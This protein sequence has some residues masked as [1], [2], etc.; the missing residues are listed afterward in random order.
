M[1][2]TLLLSCGVLSSQWHTEP[3]ALSV[4]VYHGQRAGITAEK[5]AEFDVVL[6]TYPVVEAEWR[7][8]INRYIQGIGIGLMERGRHRPQRKTMDFLSRLE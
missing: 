6:T 8:I 5:L 1:F 7:A 2:Y 3:G 4:L